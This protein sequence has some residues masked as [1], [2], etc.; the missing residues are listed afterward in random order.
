RVEDGAEQWLLGPSARLPHPLACR[1]LRFQRDLECLLLCYR[2]LL[3]LVEE[4]QRMPP[5]EPAHLLQPLDRDQRSQRLAFPLDHE[6]VM[7]QGD[8]VEQVADALAN[9]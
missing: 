9:V 7:P 8:P 5:R 4:L 1:A 2:A 6:L 3:L